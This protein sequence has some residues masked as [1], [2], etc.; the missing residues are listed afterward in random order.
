[1]ISVDTN[2]FFYGSDEGDPVRHKLA[3]QL[4]ERLPK[5]TTIVGL[6]VL[7]E[8]QYA[9][10]RKLKRA[11][12]VVA[13]AVSLY[14]QQFDTFAYTRADVLRA[15]QMVGEARLAYWDALLI[16]S[17]AGAGATVLLTEDMQDGGAVLGV[18]IVNPF[19]RDGGL[20][21]RARELLES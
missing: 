8:L 10:Q 11:P 7:G 5:R 19:G 9:L 6:Q 3:T 21:A 14:L 12:A 17:S 20:S 1:M 18:E 2:V 15:L 16:A 13:Q 4:I